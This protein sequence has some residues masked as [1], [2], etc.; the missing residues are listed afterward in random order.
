[1]FLRLRL[2]DG[3]VVQTGGAANSLLS[4]PR[5]AYARDE[6]GNDVLIPHQTIAVPKGSAEVRLNAGDVALL[7]GGT[8][9]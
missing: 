8:S 6:N 5:S 7:T 9:S 4:L 3:A 1:M 2:E